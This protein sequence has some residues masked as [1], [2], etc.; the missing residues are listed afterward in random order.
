MSSFLQVSTSPFCVSCI[1][2]SLQH[3]LGFHVNRLL[4]AAPAMVPEPLLCL[5]V[6][7][8]PASSWCTLVVSLASG[9]VVAEH[10]DG[11]GHDEAMCLFTSSCF[12]LLDLI[13]LSSW[14]PCVHCVRYEGWP[15]TEPLWGLE[16]DANICIQGLSIT[17]FV[18][19]FLLESHGAR[20][21]LFL[22][23]ILL[24]LNTRDGWSVFFFS[25]L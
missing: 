15:L 8:S 10:G 20:D 25:P 19:L 12:S 18:C 3:L 22:T 23:S 4:C 13:R 17:L 2:A 7:V 11:G 6:S 9:L 24:R 1:C 5:C 16:R 21:S 14:L